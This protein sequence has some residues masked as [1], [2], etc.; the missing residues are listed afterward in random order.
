MP[1]G[2]NTAHR[3]LPL[4]CLDYDAT[5]SD[6]LVVVHYFLFLIVLYNK[7]MDILKIKETEARLL[8]HTPDGFVRYVHDDIIWNTRMLCLVGPRRVGKTTLMLQH[9]KRSTCPEKYLYYNIDTITD[10]EIRL[11]DLADTSKV[12]S[13][14]Y[15]VFGSV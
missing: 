13:L 11:T 5:H 2:F 14:F 7:T 9:I 15:G 4:D 12:K 3:K 8:H 10:S 1:T 6:C